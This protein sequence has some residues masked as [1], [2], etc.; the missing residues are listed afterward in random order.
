MSNRPYTNNHVLQLDM[1][2]HLHVYKRP[3]TC[4]RG[5][6]WRSIAKSCRRGDCVHRR[7]L[8]RMCHMRCYL[9]IAR[10]LR[11]TETLDSLHVFMSKLRCCRC[12][13]PLQID[14]QHG[15]ALK[16]LYTSGHMLLCQ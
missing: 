12:I 13:L 16:V 1:R 3:L 11:G 10:E 5:L 8:D 4:T 7:P 9:H 2:T 6:L 15:I 14:V